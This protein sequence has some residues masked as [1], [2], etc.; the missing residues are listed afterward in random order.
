MKRKIVILL[1]A[2]LSIIGGYA[3]DSI[4]GVINEYLKV[5][6]VGTNS[7]IVDS[8]PLASTLERGDKVMLIQHSG[9]VMQRLS[10]N[11]DGNP[12][13]WDNAGMTEFLAVQNVNSG[14]KT[15][16]FTADLKNSFDSGEK[17]QLVKLYEAESAVVKGKLEVQKWDGEKGGVLALVVFQKLEL[18]A[19]IDASSAGYLGGEQNMYSG[20]CRESS[21]YYFDKNATDT[22]ALKGEGVLTIN[23]DT[24]RGIGRNINGGG[25]GNGFNTGGGGGSNYGAG[26]SSG[27]QDPSCIN[28]VKSSGGVAMQG[29]NKWKYRLIFGGGGGTS[30]YPSGETATDGGAGGGIVV[31]I[32]D[33]IKGNGY[34]IKANGESVAGDASAGAGG[35]GAGGTIALA[36][37]GFE[38]ELN[39][40]GNG[41]KGGNTTL[42]SGAGGGGSGGYVTTWATTIPS[43]TVDINLIGGGKGISTCGTNNGGSGEDGNDGKTRVPNPKNDDPDKGLELLFNGFI[44]NSVYN[45]DTAC[46]GTRPDTIIGTVPRGGESITSHKWLYSTDSIN[47]NDLTNDGEVEWFWP[48]TLYETT[49]FTRVVSDNDGLQDTALPVKIYV[50]DS[51]ESNSIVVTDTICTGTS[52]G[53]LVGSSPSGAN[54]TFSYQWEYKNTG[55]WQAGDASKN[56]VEGN[57]T[58]TILYRRIVRSAKVCFDTSETETIT[59]IED[60]T[61]NQFLSND[62]TIC[63]DLDGGLLQATSPQNGDGV[64]RYQWLESSDNISYSLVSGESDSILNLGNLQDTTF[65]KRIVYS[66]IDDVCVDTTTA[67]R[68]IVVLPDLAVDELQTDSVRYC[69]NDVPLQLRG[70]TPTGGDGSYQYYW[71]ERDL[72]QNWNI[73]AGENNV[74]LN[75]T[76]QFTDST[77][78]KRVTFSGLYDACKDSSSPLTISVIPRIDNSVPSYDTTICEAGVPLSFNSQPATG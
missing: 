56:L 9:V 68:R 55:D 75:F 11:S 13:A 65:Y 44:F 4:S 16:T 76:S 67:A 45:N 37:T 33:T 7:V 39:V 42:C 40:E 43:A 77:Q 49:Y 6:S 5:T 72:D 30:L 48:D 31:I 60:I 35:G 58:E 71:Y 15:I 3:Q 73:I 38:G 64:Y 28:E 19:D 61:N 22:A 27:K 59:V 78:Y 54:G 18:L 32:A 62:T 57:L 29:L 10:L 41:G 12:G 70:G 74:D 20:G 14:T 17:I 2:T 25:G 34:S 52:P 50:W 51:I 24:I 47:W 21:K 36:V 69:Y 23:D 46:Q 8:I 66:G 1:L 53:T 26:G 63:Y